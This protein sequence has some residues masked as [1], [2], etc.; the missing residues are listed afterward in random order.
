MTGFSSKAVWYICICVGGN[1]NQFIVAKISH[2][3]QLMSGNGVGWKNR[4]HIVLD[5]HSK[6]RSLDLVGMRSER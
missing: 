1:H 2:V 3:R 4:Y 6:L 5:I